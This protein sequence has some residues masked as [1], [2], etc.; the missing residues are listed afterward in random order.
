MD[1]L[2][3]KY[4]GNKYVDHLMT[5]LKDNYTISYD[6]DGKKYIGL[7]LD[8]DYDNREVHL[9]MLNYVVDDI[10]RFHHDQSQNPQHQPYPHIK[11]IYVEKAQYLSDAD[12]YLYSAKQTRNLYRKSRA[13]SSTA[14]KLLTQPWSQNLDLLQH[15]KKKQHNEK[16]HHFLDYV[17]THPD[18]IVTYQASDMVLA[19]HSDASYLLNTKAQIRAGGNFFMYKYS[20][21]PPNNGSVFTIAQIIKVVMSYAAEA[22]LGSLLINFREAIPSHHVL[23]DMG[24]KQPPA[25]MKTY[26]TMVLVVV[27]TNIANKRLK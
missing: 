26:N 15:R 10:K 6:W 13:L 4:V 27:T 24:Y 1:D 18:A 8:W 25:P 22:E 14:P 16:I 11:P 19:G 3:V 7:Y 17:A 21:T 12:V 20:D 5:I 9:S 2:G 23:K